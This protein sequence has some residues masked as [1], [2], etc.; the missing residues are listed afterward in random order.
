MVTCTGM[1]GEDSDRH[2]FGEVLTPP[3]TS[4]NIGRVEA[5]SERCWIPCCCYCFPICISSDPVLLFSDAPSLCLQDLHSPR[6]SPPTFPNLP[7]QGLPPP[8]GHHR[9]LLVV[10]VRN[11][12]GSISSSPSYTSH[13]PAGPVGALFR[14]D[15]NPTLSH[16]P[17]TSRGP[18]LSQMLHEPPKW[19]FPPSV[20]PKSIL[21]SSHRDPVK[22]CQLKTTLHSIAPMRPISL[23]AKSL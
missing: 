8:W 23:R 10:Q 13:P 19:W 16:H 5:A 2:V 9:T 18:H 14:K 17:L 11:R 6:G 7:S 1:K 22:T 20:P 4:I 3:L 21:K 12:G 15:L